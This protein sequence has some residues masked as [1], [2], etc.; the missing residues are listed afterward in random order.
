MSV[1]ISTPFGQAVPPA[2][3]HSVTV[4]MPGWA[5]VER[6]GQDSR[7]VIAT[8]D[9]AYPRMKP[10][11][12]I[13]RLADA[14]IHHLGLQ[15]HMC[16]L[17]TSLQ[18]ASECVEYAKSPRR[19]NGSD[20]KPVPSDQIT[21]RAFNAKDRFYAVVFPSAHSLVVSGFWSTPGVGISSRFAEAN[22]NSFDQLAEVDIP[23]DDRDRPSFE[24]PTH[25]ALRQ[26]ISF[27]LERAALD[28]TIQPRPSTDD[29]YFFPTG[30][31]SIYKP[32]SYLSTLHNGTTILFGMAFMN[33]ITAFK[34][35]GSSYKFFGNGTDADLDA[36][37]TFLSEEQSHNRKVQAIWAE[38]PANPLLVTPDLVR[39]RALADKYDT[40]LAIDD[41]IGSFA[42]I[43]ITHMTDMLITSLTKSFNGY[44]NVITGSVVLNPRSHNYPELKSLF[45]KYYIPELYIADAETL[46]R[47]SEDYLPRTTTMNHNAQS[48]VTYL[49]S[50]ALDPT[51]AIH[52]VH[53]PSLNPS[54]KHYTPFLRHA[55]PDF[56]PGHGVLFCVEL[57]DL[58]TT[59]AFY[60]VLNVHKGPHLGAP[61]TLAF[62]YTMCA[63]KKELDWAA[64]YGLRPT[65][66]RISAGLEGTE[67]L[68]GDF[69]VA[70]EA[71]DVVKRE[72][73]V[74]GGISVQSGDG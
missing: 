55:T 22:M 24:S 13:A 61:R 33:T 10:H 11:K 35:F 59:I 16:L 72:N 14:L 19:D 37:E 50:R 21:L 3:R 63:Y 71:A 12:D 34:E 39:L 40:I 45:T 53:Y 49:H 28:P 66:I 68:L 69:R 1:K 6:Y 43:D 57:E 23:K 47:N 26:R 36:L 5:N 38:F 7:A 56:T 27:Y 70:V 8:F 58:P 62:A 74:G 41:T 17:F 65:Q 48:L 20:K 25:E 9:S 15:Y 32:H 60:D 54:G 4:H 18:S 51:S 29:I 52:K 44:A 2:S 30:M 64:G 46:L 31:A 67:E 73:A 42:N